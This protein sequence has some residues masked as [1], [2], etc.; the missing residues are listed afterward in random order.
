VAKFVSRLRDRAVANAKIE[1]L[2]GNGAV[3]SISATGSHLGEA[4]I[5][6]E[7]YRACDVFGYMDYVLECSKDCR[8][9]SK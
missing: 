2:G 8:V 6:D 3:V 7:N 1:G 9:I 5:Q 4:S